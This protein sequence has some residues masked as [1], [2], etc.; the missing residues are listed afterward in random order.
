MY[1][2]NRKVKAFNPH[3]DSPDDGDAFV[4][5]V[6]RGHGRLSPDAEDFAEEFMVSAT[7]G[8]DVFEDARDEFVCEELGGPFLEIEERDLASS[9]FAAEEIASEATS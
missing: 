5:D 9:W 7:S 8:E 2:K 1:E 3:R 4:A 6:G